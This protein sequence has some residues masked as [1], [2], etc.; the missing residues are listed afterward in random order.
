M[1]PNIAI[2]TGNL[3]PDREIDCTLLRSQ[4]APDDDKPLFQ[5]TSDAPVNNTDRN[6]F[7]RYENIQRLGNLVTTRSNV[8]AVWITV[9]YFEVQPLTPQELAQLQSTKTEPEIQR[10]YPGYYKLGRELNVDTGEIERHRAFF[11]FDRSLPVG[12]SRGKDLNVEKAIL[13]ERYI[14]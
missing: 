2:G 4:P 7:F 5:Y 9:G 6:P 8:Y 3:Q 1:T 11:I 10:I 14:E 13:V 12:F